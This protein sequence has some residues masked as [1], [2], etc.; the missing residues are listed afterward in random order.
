METSEKKVFVRNATGLTRQIGAWQAFLGNILAMGIAYFFVFAFFASLIFPGANLPLTVF[1]TLIPGGIVALLYYMFSVAMPRTGGDYVWTSRIINPSIG[2]M[3]N[4]L[5]T[6]VWLSSI[7]TAVAW[8]ISYGVIP[9]MAAIGIVN[10]NPGLVTFA[11][12]TLG[13]QFTSFTIVSI[14]IALFIL[15]IF[16]GTR[17]AFRVMTVAFVVS[18][19]GAL[20]TV[21][22][23]L[24]APHSTFVAN[25]NSLSGMDYG[26]TI[27]TAGLPLGFTLAA[28]LTGSIFTMT[29]FLGF[30][31]S[32]Y[33][34]GE[35][36]RVARSQI[37]AMFGSLIFLVGIALLIYGSA[38]YSAGSDFLNAA[39]TL[40]GTSNPG[41]T[42][43]AV[44]VLNFLV[45]FAQPNTLVIALSGIALLA[46]GLGGATLFA[47]VCVRNLFSW[48]FDRIVP[49]SLT[50]LDSKR[51]SPYV[52]GIVILVLAIIFSAVYY[53]TSFF[54]YYVYGTLGLFILFWIVSLAAVIFPFRL[55]SVFAS[56]PGIVKAK[57]GGFPLISII[58][59]LGLIVNTYF[60]YATT[61]P[62]ISTPPSG[63]FIVQL[64][65]YLTV[66]LT[67]V[68][69]FIIF[70]VSYYVRKRQGVPLKA[71]FSEIPPE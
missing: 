24:S 58:G 43:P 54:T 4:F 30:F 2:F 38:Y 9:S 7:A 46:T 5:L 33:F 23:F 39:S 15:P 25:F 42:L 40:A 56:A 14:L 63:G 52:A 1:V 44:P 8:G 69:A 34:G 51:G 20:V 53:Y 11:T 60:G 48:S 57:V 21:G 29:N 41:Y 49:D 62:L 37:I 68:I 3:A 28:T 19:V 66:P 6:F 55:K 61:N 35:V 13:A 16:F 71:I 64:T 47:F 36:K 50:R 59:I 18:L 70:G 27:S 31:S 26:K 67:I 32:S 10:N 12:Q 22:A 17:W 45:A 65:S